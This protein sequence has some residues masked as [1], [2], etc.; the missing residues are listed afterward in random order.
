MTK[1]TRA[2]PSSGFHLHHLSALLPEPGRGAGPSAGVEVGAV[3]LHFLTHPSFPSQDGAEPP[4][5]P[6]RTPGK[7]ARAPRST[8]S[9]LAFGPSVLLALAQ[10]ITC[11]GVHT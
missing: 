6:A 10:Q 9:A 8:F 1:K 3:G 7:V 2:F 5:R 11:V 4:Q